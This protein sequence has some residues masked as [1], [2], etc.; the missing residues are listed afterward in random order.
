MEYKKVDLKPS[1]LLLDPNNYRFHDLV[2][3]NE[4]KKRARYQEDGVQAQAMKLL[5]ETTAFDLGALKDSIRT[6][7][8]IPIEQIVVV[9][10]DTRDDGTERFL[11]IEG[12]RRTAALKSLIEESGS[13]AADLAE[14]VKESIEKISVV[15][16]KGTE[17]EIGSYQRTLMAIRHVAGIR[18]WGPYQQ[19]KLVVEMFEEPG[20]TLGS[21][22]QKIGISSR[23]VARRY[24]ASKALKQMEDDEE[25]SEFAEPRLYVFFH[26]AVSQ[27]KVRDWLEFDNDTYKAENE[28]ARQL[29]FELLSPR[30]VDGERHPPKLTSANQQVRQLK[31]IV[32][33]PYALEVLADPDKTFDDAVLA[34]QAD[35]VE[36]DEGVVERSLATAVSMLK[37]PGLGYMD[38]NDRAKQLWAELMSQVDKIKKIFPQ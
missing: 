23:E 15:L 11:V 35:V 30:E 7:G 25:F 13:G 36:D 20:A 32:S 38:A 29:F 21:V 12:N 1:Q 34:A 5:R 24:R 33:K 6:N 10:Y 22:A 19:A 14:N 3:Y 8:F 4:V 16:L 2:G 28:D 9:P 37:K 26:E 18:E 17:E 27:P 31:D